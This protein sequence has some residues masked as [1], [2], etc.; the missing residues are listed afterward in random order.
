M[1]KAT[2]RII[3]GPKRPAIRLVEASV[4]EAS[5]ADRK[6]PLRGLLNWLVGITFTH[7]RIGPAPTRKKDGDAQRRY[8]CGNRSHKEEFRNPTKS[9]FSEE[10]K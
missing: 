8:R 3:R 6:L 2:N 5:E 4:L 7:R 10:V 9:T 1:R